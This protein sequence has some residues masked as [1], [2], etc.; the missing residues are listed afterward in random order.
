MKAPVTSPKLADGEFELFDLRIVVDEVGPRCTCAMSVGDAF[1][2]H[3]G[4][5]SV[6]E[7]RNF[8]VY[9]MQAVF[10]LLPAKQ[11]RNHPADWMETDAICTCPDPACGLLMRIERIGSRVLRHDDVSANAWAEQPK[12]D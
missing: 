2:L 6:P 10:P 1:E 11:R 12:Q 8:C 5:L 7:G 9:A 4:K 3:G